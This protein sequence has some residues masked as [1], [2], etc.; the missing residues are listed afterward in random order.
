MKETQHD[1]PLWDLKDLYETPEKALKDSWD[2]S[3][4]T[5]QALCQRVCTMRKDTPYE[6]LS[7]LL[8]EFDGVCTKVDAARAYAFLYFAQDMTREGAGAFFQNMSERLA[9][10]DALST[11]VR[12]HIALFDECYLQGALQVK[13]LGVYNTWFGR[14]LNA[15]NHVM[16]PAEEAQWVE[17]SVVAGDAWRRLAQETLGKMEIS[18]G[19]ETVNLSGALNF[20][21]DGDAD[22]RKRALGGVMSA[23]QNAAPVL[24][25]SFNTIAKDTAI[26]S[27]WRKYK[28]VD[29]SMHLVNEVA[30][31]WVDALR[32]AVVQSYSRTSHVVMETR[33]KIL[34]KKTLEAHDISAPFTSN[35]K[36][37]PWRDSLD[38]V[39]GAYD[40][41][42]PSM[43]ALLRRMLEEGRLDMAVRKGKEGGAFC[44]TTPKGPY[45]LT[46]YYGRVR[47]FLT[48]AH[49]LGHALHGLLSYDLPS[50]TRSTSLILAEVASL[51]SEK[52]CMDYAMRNISVEER[53]EFLLHYMHDQIFCIQGSISYDQ[54]E[55]NMHIK[56]ATTELTEDVLCDA[57]LSARGQ[58]FG[59]IVQLP[60]EY[61]VLWSGIPHFF[62]TPF[63]VYS[64]AFSG[65][66]M[67]ALYKQKSQQNFVEKYKTFLQK[68]GT[69]TFH[70]LRK[71]F[72][73]TDN[74]A[75]FFK[76]AL[77]SLYD[78]VEAMKQ[79]AHGS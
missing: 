68:G 74:P 67:H 78:D 15:Q 37:I 4:H 69:M 75:E 2:K 41:F 63:Y 53:K 58:F 34:G 47:D 44:Y 45:V 16:S 14:L 12:A 50:V 59:N 30:D 10:V 46:N 51:F 5:M 66:I 56:R 20:L 55:K 7:A 21:R 57:W 31:T 48:L 72:G 40:E 77:T 61:G 62:H 13:E 35:E 49:E 3:M 1:L 43:G 29:S 8:K 27:Q 52:L 39:I 71:M 64:Y 70:G 73:L 26:F 11:K 36:N 23:L 9:S 17:R 32:Q 25:T 22:V 38:L 33:A 19:N 76:D 65:L 42:D 24:T 79:A 54:F 6:T 18:C 60:K 28:G